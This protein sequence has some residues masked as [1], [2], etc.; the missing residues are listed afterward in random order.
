MAITVSLFDCVSIAHRL[1][2]SAKNW[3]VGLRGIVYI[4]KER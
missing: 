4:D 1:A 3:V 2:P